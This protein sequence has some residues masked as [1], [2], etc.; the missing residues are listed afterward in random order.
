MRE[1]HPSALDCVVS[2]LIKLA[3]TKRVLLGFFSTLARNTKGTLVG[4]G[5]LGHEGISCRRLQSQSGLCKSFKG[6]AHA[7]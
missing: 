4:I 1:S 6:S 2:V 7:C 3:R 5:L